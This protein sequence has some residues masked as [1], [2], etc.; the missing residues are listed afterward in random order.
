MSAH[1]PVGLTNP[2]PYKG[3]EDDENDHVHDAVI[4]FAPGR[5]SGKPE[6]KPQRVEKLQTVDCALGQPAFFFFSFY[7]YTI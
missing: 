2:T 7:N 6:G 1:R 4:A 5:D 3:E